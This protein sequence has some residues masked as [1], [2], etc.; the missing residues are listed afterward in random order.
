MYL[1]DQP[2]LSFGFPT[3]Q[4]SGQVNDRCRVLTRNIPSSFRDPFSHSACF[5]IFTNVV[6][7]ADLNGSYARCISV[8]VLVTPSRHSGICEAKVVARLRVTLL[9]DGRNLRKLDHLDA[10]SQC[11]F[12]GTA[13][14]MGRV[15]YADSSSMF[16]SARCAYTSVTRVLFAWPNIL[17]T[18]CS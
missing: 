11:L 2:I 14:S 6:L 4:I 12:L 1:L 10:S 13:V 17:A 18:V 7:G 15:C 5:A 9:I 16:S 8:P 3:P